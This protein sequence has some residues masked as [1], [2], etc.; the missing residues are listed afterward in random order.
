MRWRL[1]KI[2]VLGARRGNGWPFRVG[3]MSFRVSWLQLLRRKNTV[4]RR[5]PGYRRPILAVGA[6]G[7]VVRQCPAPRPRRSSSCVRLLISTRSNRPILGYASDDFPYDD[8]FARHRRRWRPR[9]RGT[10]GFCNRLDCRPSSQLH[11]EIV[12][13]K[14]GA[15][16]RADDWSDTVK[17]G[18]WASQPDPFYFILSGSFMRS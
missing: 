7:D 15:G 3:W 18:A 16:L 5:G 2:R 1:R 8:M 11:S 10:R 12:G 9:R 4:P 14:P 17:Q 13:R 6:C